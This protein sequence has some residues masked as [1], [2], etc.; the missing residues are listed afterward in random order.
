MV[1]I[2]LAGVLYVAA[3]SFDI[4]TSALMKLVEIGPGEIAATLGTTAGMM[5]IAGL[6]FVAA[7]VLLL[8][9]KIEED[10]GP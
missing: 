9:R 1:L 2:I 7:A 8:Y 10:Q 5:L 6:A 4:F 3:L